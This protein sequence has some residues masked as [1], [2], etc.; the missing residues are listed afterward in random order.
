VDAE[1]RYGYDPNF[2]VEAP[3]S[4]VGQTINFFVDGILAPETA[5]YQALGYNE[6]DLSVTMPTPTPT[7]TPTYPAWDVNMN[8]CI[9]VLDLILVGQHFGETGAPGWIRED[10]NSDGVINVLDLI[11]IGQH[12][13]EG[14]GG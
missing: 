11:I 4:L 13:G 3:V 2:F 14:C 7:P 8:G 10:V 6:L 1:G 12:F 5:V 9:N